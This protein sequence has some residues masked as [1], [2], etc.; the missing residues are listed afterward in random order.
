[1][2]AAVKEQQ[3]GGHVGGPIRRNRLFFFTAFEQ[4]RSRARQDPTTIALPSALFTAD[5]TVE[6]GDAPNLLQQFPPPRLA[7]DSRR[8]W[9]G[10]LAIAP[11]VSVDRSIALE[12]IDYRRGADQWM[13]RLSLIRLGRPD[14]LWSPYPDFVSPLDDHSENA[15]VS[16]IRSISTG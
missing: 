1:R 16:W 5:Y 6:G 4:L 11:P 10:F 14:F 3:I 9:L 2:R 7:P 12:R 13:A 15:A 8:P